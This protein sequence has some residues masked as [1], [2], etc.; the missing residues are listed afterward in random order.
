MGQSRYKIR[1]TRPPSGQTDS[2]FGND[3]VVPVLQKL[4][5]AEMGAY[6]FSQA[7]YE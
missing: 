7:A 5:C 4:G 3:I 2:I 6:M 1:G